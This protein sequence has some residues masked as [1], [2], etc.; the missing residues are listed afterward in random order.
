M[1]PINLF[2]LLIERLMKISI[3]SNMDSRKYL[4]VFYCLFVVWVF[5]WGGGLQEGNT[6]MMYRHARARAIFIY[7]IFLINSTFNTCFNKREVT[8]LVQK[9]TLFPF[10]YFCLKSLFCRSVTRIWCNFHSSA[11]LYTIDWKLCVNLILQTETIMFLLTECG[12]SNLR[13]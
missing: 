3:I 8:L 2:V 7:R 4:L 13:F 11:A 6:G 9:T 1:L 5:F 10:S 12:F